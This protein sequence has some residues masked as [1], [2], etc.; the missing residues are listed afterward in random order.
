MLTAT[1]TFTTPATIGSAKSAGFRVGLFDTTG[2]PGLAADLTASSGSPNSIYNGV[3]G[4][5]MDWDVGTGTENIMFRQHDVTQTTG[6]LMA[7]TSPDYINLSGGGST[8]SFAPN[9]SYSGVL[10]VKRTG[11]DSLDLT[12]TLF[13]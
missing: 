5:M 12:G 10:S 4:Y 8:Y 7:N 1:F 9:T 6:Q 13:Q 11:A 2:K 3:P